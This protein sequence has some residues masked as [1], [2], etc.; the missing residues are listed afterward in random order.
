MLLRELEPQ[1][2]LLGVYLPTLA[3]ASQLLRGRSEGNRIQ[4]PEQ[5]M[6]ANRG[7]QT[8]AASKIND[9]IAL[10]DTGYPAAECQDLIRKMYKNKNINWDTQ[11]IDFILL[12][13]I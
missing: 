11:L 12:R 3:L 1:A 8:T 2:G 10:L 13:Y 4:R 7:S 6:G 9:Y 5:G